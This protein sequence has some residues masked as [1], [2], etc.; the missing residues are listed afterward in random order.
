MLELVKALLDNFPVINTMTKE[1]LGDERV[2]FSLKFPITVYDF[3]NSEQEF[4]QERN[5]ETANRAEVM[6]EH[7]WLSSDCS[8][9]LPSLFS[10]TPQGHLPKNDTTHHGLG[11]LTSITNSMFSIV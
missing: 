4:K 8:V 1:Q 3:Q 7:C 11:P 10:Y 5:P 6:Q 2:Y 9:G